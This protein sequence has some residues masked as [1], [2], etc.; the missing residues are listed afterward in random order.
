MFIPG[1]EIPH[2]CFQ[3][4]D[5]PCVNVCPTNALSINGETGAVNVDVSKC[6]A[7]GLCINICPGKVPHMHPKKNHIVIC[8]LCDGNP[9]CVEA[10]QQGKWNTLKVTSRSEGISYKVFAKTP[11]KL[12][13]E[14]SK[15]LL[16]ED[17]AK[18]VRV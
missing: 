17:I 15:K 4:E 3:C 13:F 7:C 12:T 5:Y 2:L 6:S 14:V 18:E 9:K 16:G 8:D 1:V 11:E 10:C